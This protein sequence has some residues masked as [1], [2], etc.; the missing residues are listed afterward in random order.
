MIAICHLLGFRLDS[1]KEIKI[2]DTFLIRKLSVTESV[3][4]KEKFYLGHNY[5]LFGL[6]DFQYC[7]EIK[8]KI[9]KKVLEP[10]KSFEEYNRSIEKRQGFLGD[11]HQK[12]FRFIFAM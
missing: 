11:L 1:S 6:K 2:N 5:F 8:N 7:I 10:V 4:L 12:F 9:N 3:S